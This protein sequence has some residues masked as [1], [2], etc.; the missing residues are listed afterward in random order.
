MYLIGKEEVDAVRKVIESG[1]LFRYRGGEGGETDGFEEEF[2]AKIRTEHTLAVTSG[3]AAL[4]CGLAGMGIGPGDEVIVPAYTFM[5]TALAPLAV[6]AVP[7]IAEIDESLTLD[8]ANLERKITPRTKAVI[9]V[10]M[11]GLPCDMETIGRIARDHGIRVLEDCCQAVGGSYGSK[12]LG[13]LGDAGAFSF[14]QFKIITCG[15]GGA[16]TTNNNVLYERAMIYHDGGC[17]FRKHAEEMGIPFYAGSNFRMNEILSTILRVQLK[18]LDGIIEGLRREKRVMMEELCDEVAFSPNPINDP[19]GECAT[20]LSLLL[21]SRD[22]SRAFIDLITKKGIGASS[23]IDSGRH[24]YRNWEPILHKRGAHHPE[25]D[26]YRLTDSPP[27]YSPDMCPRTL[28]ILERTVCIPT[29]PTRTAEQT[30]TI[31][32]GI[33]QAAQQIAGK[34]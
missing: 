24:V 29:N 19:E 34:T 5:A 26:P 1:Q 25:Y 10:H 18:R 28:S 14:N 15:E 4:I 6:G 20:T 21:E 8:P 3:T 22:D 7:V 27:E 9:P 11:L 16:L 13:S 17:V 31:I 30:Q 23:P 33:K 32:Q 12:R 2:A